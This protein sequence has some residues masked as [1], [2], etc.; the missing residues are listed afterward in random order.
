MYRWMGPHFHDWIDYN[1][2][3]VSHLR[4]F[5]VASHACVFRG[6]RVSSEGR[7]EIRAPINTPVWE[8]KNWGKKL[9]LLDTCVVCLQSVLVKCPSSVKWSSCYKRRSL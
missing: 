7:D 6:A 5:W 9:N 3:R 4:D 2:D 1:H 8:A